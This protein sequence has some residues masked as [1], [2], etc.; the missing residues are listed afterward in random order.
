MEK[1]AKEY[2]E[3]D[4]NVILLDEETDG[5]DNLDNNNKIFIVYT[6]LP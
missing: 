1:S 4:D 2:K 6:T 3:S 5:D